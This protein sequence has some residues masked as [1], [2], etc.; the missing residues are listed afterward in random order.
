[1]GSLQEALSSAFAAQGTKLEP[2][3]A[4]AKRPL[5]IVLRKDSKGQKNLV[6]VK[7]GPSQG[8]RQKK[9]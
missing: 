4:E 7:Y 1:M 5:K 3:S 8:K 9:R 2:P 6:V